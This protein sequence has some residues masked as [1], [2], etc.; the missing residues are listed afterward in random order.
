MKNPKLQ[1]TGPKRKRRFG[2]A[3]LFG[4]VLIPSQKSPAK[5]LLLAVTAGLAT[6]LGNATA[7]DAEYTKR[8]PRRRD[9]SRATNPTGDNEESSLSPCPPLPPVQTAR[10]AI[11]AERP[12]SATR[13]TR[14]LDCNL[15][16]M[17]GFAAAHG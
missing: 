5:T 6:A 10:R 17:A 14:A 7:K 8:N 3:P 4:N 15:D 2:A 11:A 13:P 16:A 1:G 9:T 12:S